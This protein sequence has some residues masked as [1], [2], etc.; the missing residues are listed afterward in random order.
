MIGSSE[1]NKSHIEFQSR[2]YKTNVACPGSIQPLTLRPSSWLG[3]PFRRQQL[4]AAAFQDE[5]N[6]SEGS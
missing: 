4:L 1:I 2:L 5:E 3:L 6:A